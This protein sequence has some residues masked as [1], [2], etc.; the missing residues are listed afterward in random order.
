MKLS[1][2]EK[3]GITFGSL[4]SVFY[5]INTL[6]NIV[7]FGLIFSTCYISGLLFGVIFGGPIGFTLITAVIL[8]NGASYGVA[9]ADILYYLT[10]IIVPIISIIFFIYI[11]PWFS[12]L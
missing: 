2:R 4:T 8:Y 12:R 6:L 5:S 11:T 7:L 9:K 1:L 10:V 3:Q